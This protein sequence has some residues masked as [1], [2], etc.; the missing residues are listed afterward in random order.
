MKLRSKPVERA[1]KYIQNKLYTAFCLII[2]RPP[3]SKWVI[4]YFYKFVIGPE[5]DRCLK[6][7][8]LPMRVHYYSPVPDLEDLKQRKV[9]GK[10]SEL[11]GIDFNA[12]RH[13]SFLK[14]LG[15]KFGK[16]CNWSSRPGREEEFVMGNQSFLF[17]CAASL[18]SMIR[19][20]KP[21]K[22]IEIGSGNS[23]IIISEAIGKNRAES[24]HKTQY[25]II[26]PYPGAKIEKKK[27][28]HDRLVKKRVELLNPKFF[29][30]LSQNDILFIDSGHTVRIGSDV[31]YLYLDVLPRLK[32]GVIIHCHDIDLP[33]EYPQCYATDNRFRQFWTES[34]LLQAFLACNDK[35]DILLPMTYLMKNYKKEF[36]KL[37]PHYDPSIPGGRLAISPS[38]WMRRK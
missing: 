24:G 22:I 27:V 29:D 15:K 1:K 5:S 38:F 25:T 16:E 6:R 33:Y 21:K 13:L 32:P 2:E 14:K 17:G 31:N 4:E 3:F 20:F 11:Q 35:F 30:Q 28:P 8:Y 34:Y 37:F 36:K 26:D 12:K 10:K 9:W 23:S 7:G 19:E 18:H